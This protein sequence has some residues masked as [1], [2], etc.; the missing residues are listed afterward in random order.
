MI[1]SSALLMSAESPTNDATETPG[2]CRSA[3]ALL[4]QELVTTR[5]ALATALRELADSRAG[6]PKALRG[7]MRDS[8]TGMPNRL[9]F[10]R[11][12]TCTLQ[13]HARLAQCFCLVFMD[14]DGVKSINDRYGHQVG[15]ALLRVVG[16]RLMRSWRGD[17]FVSP[18]GGDEFLCLLPNVQH[19]AQARAIGAKLIDVVSTPCRIGSLKVQVRASAGIALYP[20]DGASTESLVEGADHAMLWAKTRQAVVATASQLRAVSSQ[21]RISGVDEPA[22]GY[23]VARPGSA[24]ARPA[25]LACCG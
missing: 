10:E 2:H 7:A 4:E 19:A 5:D 14:L 24:R 21:K 18:Y 16:R 15:D 20:H 8:L 9:A 3:C 22:N 13:E 12:S 17:D 23:C 6:E 1:S 25:V 11:R